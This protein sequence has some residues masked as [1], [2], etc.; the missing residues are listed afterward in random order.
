MRIRAV[1]PASSNVSTIACQFIQ[2]SPLM[3]LD[4]HDFR[5]L[6]QRH[7]RIPDLQAQLLERV[8]RDDRSDLMFPHLQVDLRENGVALDSR[9]FAD[10]LIATAD[11]IAAGRFPEPAIEQRLLEPVPSPDFGARNL[12]LP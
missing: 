1:K 4:D 10:E 6:H 11:V 9:D 12:A 3:L 8:P 5:R 7:R 2:T